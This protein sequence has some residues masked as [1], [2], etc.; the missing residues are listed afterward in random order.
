VQ[1]RD[2]AVAGVRDDGGGEQR[3]RILSMQ[4]GQERREPGAEL[5][6]RQEQRH[7][8]G[9]GQRGRQEVV[10]GGLPAARVAGVG[11]VPAARGVLDGPGQLR[12]PAAVQQPRIRHGQGQRE[13]AVGMVPDAG[14]VG[15]LGQPAEEVRSQRLGQRLHGRRPAPGVCIVGPAGQLMAEPQRPAPAVMPQ[16]GPAEARVLGL[17]GQP[18]RGELGVE[19]GSDPGRGHRAGNRLEQ[20]DQD[21][22]HLHAGVPVVAAVEHR[23]PVPRLARELPRAGHQRGHQ[24]RVFPGN[25]LQRQPG[26]TIRLGVQPAS[27]LRREI[28]C[29]S[30]GRTGPAAG[31]RP[32]GWR[33]RRQAFRVPTGPG[34]CTPRS[35]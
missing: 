35:A 24:R 16:A 30:C 21:P 3:G 4:T 10:P 17:R 13:R 18:V 7:Q 11:G 19:R 9:L 28:H 25:V 27:P 23:R 5:P 31:R 34:P 22:V 12:P 14:R 15:G 8:L 1:V 2:L 26:V 29:V 32:G 20:P 6:G 33:T